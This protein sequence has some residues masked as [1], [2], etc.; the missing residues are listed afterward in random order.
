VVVTKPNESPKKPPDGPSRKASNRSSK[1]L[2]N[3]ASKRSSK[4]ASSRTP[5]T[6]PSRKPLSSDAILEALRAFGLGYP[7]AH[8]KSPWPDHLDLA[9]NDKTFAYLSA[10]GQPFGVSCKLSHSAS[11]ALLLPFA[12]PTAY[13]LGKSGWV[14]AQFAAGETPPLDLLKEWID[15]SYRAQAPRKLIATLPPPR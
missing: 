12:T 13:G 10:P 4:A 2:P 8:T 15:E 11:A 6:K 5:S 9:V 3:K 1:K 14:T 7:G